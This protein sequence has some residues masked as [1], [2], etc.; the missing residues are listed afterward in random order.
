MKPEM[1]DDVR[2]AYE[3]MKA[4]FLYKKAARRVTNHLHGDEHVFMM[5]S[6][7][8]VRGAG[9]LALTDRRLLYVQD[10]GGL[11]Y[12]H[13]HSTSLDSI[14][15]VTWTMNTFSGTMKVHTTGGEVLEARQ[16]VIGEGSEFADRLQEQAR[17]YRQQNSTQPVAEDSSTQTLHTLWKQGV[18]TEEEFLTALK[19]L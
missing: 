6:A 10:A 17:L 5:T 12:E 3:Q 9:L 2:I 11:G 18:L 4:K 14:T 1:R 8:Y 13:I 7:L 15:T 16:M 19:R